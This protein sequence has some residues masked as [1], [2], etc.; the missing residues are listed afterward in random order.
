VRFFG[1]IFLLLA[2]LSFVPSDTPVSPVASARIDSSYKQLWQQKNI[3]PAPLSTDEEFLRR[4]YLDLTGRIP[5]RSQAEAFLGSK[6]PQKRSLLIETLLSSD[7]FR[8]YFSSLWTNLFLRHKEDRFVDRKAFQSWLQNELRM[9]R[10]WD[11]IA[12]QLIT[13][14]GNLQDNPPLNWYMMHRLK[15]ADLADDTARYFLG[16]QLGCARCHNHPQDQWTMED[17]YG[18]AA[19]YDGLRRDQLTFM[20]KVQNRTT[21]EKKGEIKKEYKEKMNQEDSPDPKE[22]AEIKKLLVENQDEIRNSIRLKQQNTSDITTEIRGE[23]KTF[24]MKFLMEPHPAHI[25]EGKREALASWVTSRENPFFAKAFLN[26]I[27][28]QLMGTGFVEPVDGMRSSN[29]SSNPE[30]LDFLAADFIRHDY[31][32]KYIF[33]VIANSRIY[34]LSSKSQAEEKSCC[35]QTAKLKLLNADQLLNSIM[36]A[37]SM[38]EVMRSRKPEEFEEKRK[39]IYQQFVFLFDND[40]NQG[41]E[42]EFQGT[43]SQALF[44]MN[45][46]MTNEAL[47]PIEGNSTDSILSEYKGKEDRLEKIYLTVLSREP[48]N[49]ERRQFLSYLARQEGGR[50]AYLDL[51]WTL[52]NSHEFIFNH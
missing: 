7:Q 34:Q 23:N 12:R 10:S 48:D 4:I 28:A 45:G 2:A 39:L 30:L 43:I 3:Q 52:L 25:R 21:K 36:V 5:T 9:N 37:T 14:E 32:V 6:A 50:S 51:F 26:R 42:Q 33:S 16:I 15:A 46:R 47:R 17:F 27:W 29:D 13:A 20:E 38:D 35:Y 44:L 1:S 41:K 31:D 24:P 19:F 18:L 22:M 11:E 40:D 49:E 8:E